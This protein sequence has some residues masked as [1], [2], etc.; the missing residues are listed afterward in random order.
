[1]VQ[2][3]L[4]GIIDTSSKRMR[5]WEERHDKHEDSCGRADADMSGESQTTWVE[6]SPSDQ[7]SRST[8]SFDVPC[9]RNI[10]DYD[11][12]SPDEYAE[13]MKVREVVWVV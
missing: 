9:C 8:T 1:M 7:K 12:L 5:G 3:A 11:S 2:E 6:I 13:L 4:R 10:D